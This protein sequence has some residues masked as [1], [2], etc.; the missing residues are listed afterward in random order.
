MPIARVQMPDGR[1]ARFEVP[2][3]MSPQDIEA[4]AQTNIDDLQKQQE[5]TAQQQPV[6]QQ[7]PQTKSVFDWAGDKIKEQFNSLGNFPKNPDRIANQTFEQAKPAINDAI[8]TAGMMSI[9]S[10]LLNTGLKRIA[11]GAAGGASREEGLKDKLKGAASGAALSM[12]A[13]SVPVIQGM[14]EAGKRTIYD[15]RFNQDKIIGA[16]L[17]RFA[18]DPNN[19]NV[20]ARTEKALN[21]TKQFIRGSNPTTA[22]AG[23]NGGLWA[24]DKALM[25]REQAAYRDIA[26]MQNL[27]RVKSLKELGL[28]EG[29]KKQGQVFQDEAVKYLNQAKDT[30]ANINLSPVEKLIETTLGTG[31][32]KQTQVRSA[33]EKLNGLL[34]DKN[35]NLETNLDQ[36]QGIRNEIGVMLSGKLAGDAGNVRFASGQVGEVK[37]AIDDAIEQA[38]AS[39]GNS[40]LHRAFVNQYRQGAQMINRADDLNTLLQRSSTTGQV[41][42]IGMIGAGAYGPTGAMNPGEILSPAKLNNFMKSDAWKKSSQNLTPKQVDRVQNVQ[43]D[44]LRSVPLDIKRGSDTFQNMATDYI[45]QG[46]ANE[47]LIKNIIASAGKGVSKVEKT[48]GVGGLLNFVVPSSNVLENPELRHGLLKAMTDPK[49]AAKLM[50]DYREFSPVGLGDIPA[51]L[52]GQGLI[53]TQQNGNQQGKRP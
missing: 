52:Q 11:T 44:L 7:E 20:L 48:P 34:R 46:I 36:I 28:S 15:P 31:A 39:S 42:E 32:G 37:G 2:A 50:K 6:E 41:P 17:K 19:P 35:G 53:W 47:G 30:G 24:L 51:K 22:Q 40:G 33:L 14:I 43:K 4:L 29:A 26:D 18:E 21:N 27:A 49:Y 23:G 9:P 1:I 8:A 13:E 25:S 16:T 10:G 3:D 38:L 45:M 12:A 5:T